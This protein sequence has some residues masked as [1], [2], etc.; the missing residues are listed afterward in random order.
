MQHFHL[1]FGTGWESAPE[2]AS[3]N[4]ITQHDFWAATFFFAIQLHKQQYFTHE[5]HLV[6]SVVECTDLECNTLS[7]NCKKIT[8]CWKCLWARDCFQH[9]EA[10]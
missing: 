1:G 5:Y 3:S 9:L 6:S 2:L 10:K 7:L 4:N 8:L